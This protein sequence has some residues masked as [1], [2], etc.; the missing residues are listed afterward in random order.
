M[1]ELHVDG[2][3]GQIANDRLTGKVDET[4]TSTVQPPVDVVRPVA[5]D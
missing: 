2:W 4:S 1:D 3:I 5:A